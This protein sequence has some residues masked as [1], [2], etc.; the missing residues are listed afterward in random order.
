MKRFE[1]PSDLLVGYAPIDDEHRHLVALFNGMVSLPETA[2]AAQFAETYEKFAC[3]F[4]AHC[5]S[6]IDLLR[7]IDYPDTE[8][9]AKHHDDLIAQARKFGDAT[10]TQKYTGRSKQQFLSKAIWIFLED[11]IGEDPKV[12]SF[13]MDRGILNTP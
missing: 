2:S 3:A 4:E 9:H 10:K 12:K 7:G 1:I 11:A 6:E 13:L 8:S 5:T